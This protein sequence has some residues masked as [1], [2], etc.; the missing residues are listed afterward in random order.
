MVSEV[1]I[2]SAPRASTEPRNAGSST[3]T[4]TSDPSAATNSTAATDAAKHG[5]VLPDP[6]VPVAHAPARLMCGSE[7]RLCSAKPASCKTVLSSPK[8]SP[9]AAVTVRVSASTSITGG[10]PASETRS[11]SLSAMVLNVWPVPNAWIR[12]ASATS[13]CNRSTLGGRCTTS[14]E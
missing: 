14:V 3:P 7:P 10:S 13:L 5:F 4:R 11:P 1:T 2:P 9:A 12:S 8:R 6:C